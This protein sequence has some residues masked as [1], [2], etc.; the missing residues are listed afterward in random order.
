MTC[1]YVMNT[2]K[3]INPDDMQVRYEYHEYLQSG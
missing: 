1:R 3:T 2:V